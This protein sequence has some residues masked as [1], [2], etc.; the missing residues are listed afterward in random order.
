MNAMSMVKR[1]LFFVLATVVV[2]LPAS[3]SAYYVSSDFRPLF[4]FW[5]PSDT[6][7]PDFE[8]SDQSFWEASIFSEGKDDEF[9]YYELQMTLIWDAHFSGPHP[10]FWIDLSDPIDEY[11]TVTSTSGSRSWTQ[12][13]RGGTRIGGAVSTGWVEFP[14]YLSTVNI[15]MRFR[16]LDAYNTIPDPPD[17]T[18]SVPVPGSLPLVGMGLIGLV[19]LRKK[20]RK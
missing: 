20:R 14:D 3:A 11:L 17:T 2:I 12:V 7:E 1:Q 19:G 8:K 15:D 9:N 6:G 18:P 4:I 13:M 10:G 5:Y 16:I